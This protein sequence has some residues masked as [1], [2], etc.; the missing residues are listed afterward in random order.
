MGQRVYADT[1]DRS[2][3]PSEQHRLPKAMRPLFLHAPAGGLPT[4]IAAG[5]RVVIEA[6]LAVGFVRPR[7]NVTRID[8][9]SGTAVRR[10]VTLGTPA[11]SLAA[12]VQTAPQWLPRGQSRR[13]APRSGTVNG[14]ASSMPASGNLE[15]FKGSLWP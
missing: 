12:C 10:S 2:L 1:P 11:S 5:W 6:P 15:R 3:N 14:L 9:R 4:K 7:G 13:L 8:H